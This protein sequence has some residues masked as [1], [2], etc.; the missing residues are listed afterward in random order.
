MMRVDK[1]NLSHL[2][3]SNFAHKNFLSTTPARTTSAIIIW[4][5]KSPPPWRRRVIEVGV[6]APAK[7][8]AVA[9]H[10]LTCND[11][12]ADRATVFAFCLPG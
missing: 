11:L 10:T 9:L 3:V 6:P 8:F 7:A 1:R 5:V 4:P 12:T 2:P